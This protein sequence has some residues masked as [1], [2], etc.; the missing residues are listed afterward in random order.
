[1]QFELMLFFFHHSS[2][3]SSGI[4]RPSGFTIHIMKKVLLIPPVKKLNITVNH[5]QETMGAVGH[6]PLILNL[7]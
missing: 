4:D 2:L 5:R 3:S 6:C 1:M 7:Q